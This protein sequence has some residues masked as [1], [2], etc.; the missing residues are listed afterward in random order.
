MQCDY[1]DADACRSCA[2]MGVPYAVQLTDKDRHV[3]EV[4]A[5]IT[6]DAQWH[7][8]FAGAPEAFRNKAKLVVGG[9][10]GAVTLGILGADGEGVDLRHCGL[11]EPGLQAVIPRV[12][13]V[14]DELSLEPYDVAARR[15]E[16]KHVILTISPRGDVMMRLVIR[17]RKHLALLESRLSR[18]LA[19]LPEVRVLTVNLQPEH[20]AV[21]EGETEIVLTDQQ[22]LAMP[23]NDIEL[24]LRPASFFQTNTAV[25]SG[26]YTQAQQWM[27]DRAP[28]SVVDLYCGVGGFALHA[29]A[30]PTPPEHI[31]GIEIAPDA[32]ASAERTAAELGW[33][34]RVA[35][36]VGDATMGS[37]RAS[38]LL[39]SEGSLAIV[40]P[41]RRGIGPQLSEWLQ[42]A[43][44]QTIIYSSCNVES[45]ARDLRSL[46]QFAVTE[47]R[48]FDMFPQTGHH[49]VIALLD[50]NA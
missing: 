15:G 24:H 48:L 19:S 44:P 3:R 16:L 31:L 28:T 46:D 49:E 23:V 11:H 30:L 2:L 18:I 7:Q 47:A 12:A 34:N 50:R 5:P 26:L 22:T 32:V 8:P 6:R 42:S 33:S 29:A 39:A 35:F 37:S 20:K 17:S 21:L 38:D 10:P 9:E 40:N 36:E 4:L 14:L 13:Q 25:A 27:A 43:R 45:L 1:F 41:P